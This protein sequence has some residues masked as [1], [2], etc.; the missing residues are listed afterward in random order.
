MCIRDRHKG[1]TKDDT[2]HVRGTARSP[3]AP[4]SV[5]SLCGGGRA[6]AAGAA[7]GNRPVGS[8]DVG[9]LVTRTTFWSP[10]QHPDPCESCVPPL[11]RAATC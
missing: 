9:F 6:A 2:L 7:G 1:C 8:G 10:T 4:L 3:P 11:G 5:P